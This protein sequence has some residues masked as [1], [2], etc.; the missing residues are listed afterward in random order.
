[1]ARKSRDKGLSGEREVAAVYIDHGF[2]V[3][4]LEGL[5]DHLVVGHGLVIHSEVKRTES[6]RLW[7]C[8]AQCWSE[9]PAGTLP[10]LAY[11]RNRSP[12]T[13]TLRL[14]DLCEALAR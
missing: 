8:L 12:W 7:D 2:A 4:G 14:E 10:V 6:I 1:M 5:G 13:A 3:R 9:A 11:R